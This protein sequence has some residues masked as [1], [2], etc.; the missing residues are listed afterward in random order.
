MRAFAIIRVTSVH[1]QGS[2]ED[3]RPPRVAHQTRGLRL[4]HKPDAATYELPAAVAY[5]AFHCP[6]VAAPR[7]IGPRP[8]ALEPHTPQAARSSCGGSPPLP[9][10]P[11]T[12]CVRAARRRLAQLREC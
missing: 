7:R 10:S 4:W 3:V 6:E 12:H 8:P 9:G 2:E 11:R 5:I 1:V